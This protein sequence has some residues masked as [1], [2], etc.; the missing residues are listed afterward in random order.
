MKKIILLSLFGFIFSSIF[1]GLGTSENSTTDENYLATSW[2]LGWMVY[3]QIM[4]S[5]V[6]F[7][8]GGEGTM[9]SSTYGID[10]IEQSL[11]YNVTLLKPFNVSKI[12][13]GIGIILGMRQIEEY[14]SMENLI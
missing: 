5:Y 10:T 6:G 4:D 3:S 14:C 11:S 8:L 1:I 13:N 7:D 2:S 9:S 12:K